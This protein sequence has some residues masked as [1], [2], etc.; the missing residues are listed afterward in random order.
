MQR[1][2]LSFSLPNLYIQEWDLRN[3]QQIAECLRHSDTVYN[4]VGRN[5]ETKYVEIYQFH[6]VSNFL[7]FS[8]QE[9]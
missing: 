4:L 6:Q 7:P 5:Y 2:T 8:P 3:E 9:L 1:G